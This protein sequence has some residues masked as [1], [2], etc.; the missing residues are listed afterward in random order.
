VAS[1][2]ATSDDCAYHY[3]IGTLTLAAEA[4]SLGRDL[5]A[6]QV[7]L[8]GKLQDANRSCAELDGRVDDPISIDLTPDGDICILQRVPADDSV[9][10]VADGDYACDPKSLPPR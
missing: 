8:R 1:S 3:D 10:M 6:K 2:D 9:P 5:E 7:L 4:N